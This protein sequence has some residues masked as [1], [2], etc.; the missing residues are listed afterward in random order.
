MI[1]FY[2]ILFLGLTSILGSTSES[3][4]QRDLDVMRRMNSMMP[5]PMEIDEER[6]IA[7]GIRRLES[8]HVIIYTDIRDRADVDELGQV[9]DLGVAQLCE[10]FEVEPE[11]LEGWQVSAFLMQDKE[12]FRKA[13]LY[14]ETLPDFPAGYNLGHH[15]WVYLQPGD[16]YTRHLLLH[17]ATHAF[18]QWNLG[19]SGVA[20]YSEGMAE[21]LGVHRWK[22]GQ[23]QMNY[24]LRGKEEAEYWGRVKIINEDVA[25]GEAKTLEQVLRINSISF[26]NVR[27]YAWAWAACKFFSQHPL[28]KSQF[29]NLQSHADDLTGGFNRRFYRAVRND[30]ETLKKDWQLYISEMDYGISVEQLSIFDAGAGDDDSSFS[31]DATRGWQKTSFVVEAGKSYTIMA[32]GRY[33]IAD[34]D[35]PWPCEPGGI[36]IEYYRGQPLGMLMAG[37]IGNDEEADAALGADG[38][39]RQK[40]IGLRGTFTA[41]SNGVLCFRVNESPAKLDDNS[42]TLVVNITEK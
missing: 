22:Q 42:G 37:M 19:G 23:L 27:S 18:M 5:A 12:K 34:K 40:A 7:N 2:S 11:S 10:Y 17:E 29:A 25:A 13:G 15:M 32:R 14:P 16:Y 38:L 6:V 28:S 33:Q 9:F 31:I 26:R 24:R 1:K 36:T 21:M 20:W 41:E 8:K 35:Q 4:G 3:F 39:V 30:W